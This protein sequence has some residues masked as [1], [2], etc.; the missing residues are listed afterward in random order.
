MKWVFVENCVL[1][2]C[3]TVLILMTHQWYWIFM[4]LF[5][6]GFSKSR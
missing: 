2:I 4:M 5:C 6:N 1:A 3:T